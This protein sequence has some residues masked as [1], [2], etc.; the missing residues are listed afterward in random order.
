MPDETVTP[1]DTAGA[2]SDTA[3]GTS[4][5]Y[6]GAVWL[7]YNNAVGAARVTPYVQFQHD[8][9]G[10]SPAPAGPFVDGRK[11]V[12]AGLG[13]NYLERWSADVSYTLYAGSANYLSDR[14]FVSLSLSYSF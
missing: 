10:S 2:G 8:V 9:S 7:D 1:L 6:R 5:G 4:W 14:D 3:D 13:V 12:T 11:A